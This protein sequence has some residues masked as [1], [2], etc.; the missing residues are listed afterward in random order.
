MRNAAN[1]FLQ[2][3]LGARYRTKSIYFQLLYYNLLCTVQVGFHEVGLSPIIFDEKKVLLLSTVCSEVGLV[4]IMM[5]HSSGSKII[6][7]STR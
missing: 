5:S 1:T 2:T 6:A 7:E 3:C 4:V